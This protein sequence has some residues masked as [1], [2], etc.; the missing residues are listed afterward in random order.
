MTAYWENVGYLLEY[1]KN[2]KNDF[3]NYWKIKKSKNEFLNYWKMEKSKI[4]FWIFRLKPQDLIPW[5][6][7]PRFEPL[8]LPCQIAPPHKKCTSPSK[9]EV[10][11]QLMAVLQGGNINNIKIH[12]LFFS[13]SNNSKNIFFI[14]SFSNKYPTFS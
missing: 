9:Q 14:F 2:N 10:R 6:G 7:T 8:D 1:E 5:T 13:F 3:L 11:R 4:N 12:F